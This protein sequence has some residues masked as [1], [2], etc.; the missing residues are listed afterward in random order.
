MTRRSTATAEGPFVYK[1][2][3]CGRLHVKVPCEESEA[4][5]V[6]RAEFR[7]GLEAKRGTTMKRRR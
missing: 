4:R 6:Q 5:E 7:A 3:R 2:C 1:P